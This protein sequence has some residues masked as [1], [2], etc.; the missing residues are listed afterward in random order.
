[1]LPCNEHNSKYRA[2]DPRGLC[3]MET[4]HELC[5]FCQE[6]ELITRDQA[7]AFR[8]WTRKGYVFCRV[9]VPMGMCQ[10]CGRESFTTAAEEIVR[11][12]VR[13]EYDKL[14]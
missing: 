12:A 2:F 5:V 10:A 11:A 9:V 14:P 7:V 6:G 8:Q 1:M 13:R 3:R 4:N